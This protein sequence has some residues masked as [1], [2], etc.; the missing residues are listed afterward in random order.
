MANKMKLTSSGILLFLMLMSSIPFSL[1]DIIFDSTIQPIA[2]DE[3]IYEDNDSIETAYNV[4][5]PSDYTYL[6]YIINEGDDDWF[7]I[8][9][10]VGENISI[11]LNTINSNMEISF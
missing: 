3:D 8:H 10:N 6:Q 2:S 9:L 4:D 11:F 5:Y 1:N 7:K